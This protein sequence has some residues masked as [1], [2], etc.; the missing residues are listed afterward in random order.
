MTKEDTFISSQA[1]EI[2]S[3]LPSWSGY[4]Y[5]RQPPTLQVGLTDSTDVINVTKHFKIFVSLVLNILAQNIN[6]QFPYREVEI[7][8]N[9]LY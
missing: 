2:L 4:F 5:G 1:Q 7:P 3:K 6:Q 8:I 9:N